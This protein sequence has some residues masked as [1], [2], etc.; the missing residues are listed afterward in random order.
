MFWKYNGQTGQSSLPFGFQ[1][2]GQLS[3]T[4]VHYVFPFYEQIFNNEYILG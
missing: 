2:D 1:I 3:D 4:V